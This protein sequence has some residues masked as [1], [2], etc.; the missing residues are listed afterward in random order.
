LVRLLVQTRRR[1]V[2]LWQ[3]RVLRATFQ[4]EVHG[5]PAASLQDLYQDIWE[6]R[7]AQGV[8]HHAHQSRE[9]ADVRQK[10]LQATQHP[11][12]VTR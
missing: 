11:A 3:Y 7:A 8:R 2:A 9:R 5:E 10:G 12:L 1:H 4:R 6:G